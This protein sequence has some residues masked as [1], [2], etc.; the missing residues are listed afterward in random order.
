MAETVLYDKEAAGDR[1][2]AIAW[3]T[4]NR[5][6]VHN[7]LNLEVRDALWEALQA[8]RADPEVGVVVLKGAGDLAFSAGADLHD[9]GTAPSITEARRGRQE[10]DVWGLMASFEKPLVAAL[11]GYTLG[12]GCEMALLCDLRIAA[13]EVQIGLPEVKLGY[14]P[15]AGG[16]QTLPRL[17]GP[18]HALFMILSG[19]PVD[20]QTAFEFGL[21]EW[22]VP[23]AEL[24]SRA[25]SVA[26][27]ILRRP[28]AV[29]RSTKEAVL[30]GLDLPLQEGLALEARLRRRSTATE[31]A[32]TRG[33]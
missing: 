21:V 33:G 26:S 17:I 2:R 1:G 24:Y 11:Q 6:E 8:L 29:V 10:R 14:I 4:L 23:R 16:S 25:R 9:F 20:A 18:T 15:S 7:A 5:P 30:R 13:E 3:L 19:E 32:G 12:A 22:V 27:E 28:D 31:R